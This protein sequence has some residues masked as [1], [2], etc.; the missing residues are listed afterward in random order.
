MSKI[1]CDNKKIYVNGKPQKI[2]SGAMHYFR[3]HPDYWQDR[4]LKLKEMGCNCVET[5]VCWNLHEKK[6]GEFDFTDWLDLGKYID[7]ANDMGLYAIVR[8]GPY[9][10]SEWDFGGMPWWLLTYSEM[11]LR[12]SNELFL[13]KCKPYLEK[14]C[15]II[16]P[17]LI[18]NGGNI[19]MVQIE[20]EYGSFGNDK[21]YLMWYKKFYAD[22]KIDCPLFTS[23]GETE[24]LLNNG[25]LPDVYASVN[26]RKD[27]ERCL[28][29]LQKYHGNQ[30]GMV[31]ELWNGRGQQWGEEF[32]RRDIDEV[33]ESVESALKY[34]EL[35]NLYMFHGGTTFGF[36]NGAHDTG[37]KFLVQTTSY[38]V[39]APL[40]EYGIRTPK[41]YAEQKVIAK[42]L[43]ISVQNTAKDPEIRE[44][45]Q[46]K[47][48]GESVI[49]KELVKK[50]DS[51][52]VKSMEY[53]GQGYGYI[54]YTTT[55]FVGEKGAKIIL[56]AVHDVAHVYVDGKYEKTILRNDQDKAFELSKKGNYKIQINVENLGRIN[57]GVDLIDRKG[58][59]GDIVVF[60]YEYNVKIKAFN[61]QV[62]SIE[63]DSLPTKFDSKVKVNEPALY[64]YEINV[65][66]K[67]DT[68]LRLDGF[69]RGVAFVNGFN[70]GRHWTIEHTENKLYIPAPLLNEGKNEIVIFDVLATDKE[71]K[72]VLSNQI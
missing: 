27:S 17:R 41:Y 59:I 31:L 43:S 35:V 45:G 62:Y 60:D 47:L 53:Y 58:L 37:E 67:A 13:Q 15:E 40:N 8:P 22:Q 14:V 26:Y 42:A 49:T 30:P 10:C 55:V 11:D 34:A 18:D 56:P 70:L 28:K 38:D 65:D 61:Y 48:V 12:C 39:D 1:Y 71:K 4:L 29:N 69:T 3:I 46:A 54:V 21:E 66:K 51:A 50:H 5:Y 32:V 23:D 36:M 6:E 16:R 72:V 19:I 57:Y 52:N 44:Y 33:A 20:N 64:Q 7:M 2:M 68:I 9:I 25:T 63:L 24:F